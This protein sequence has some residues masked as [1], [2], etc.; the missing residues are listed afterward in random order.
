MDWPFLISGVIIIGITWLMIELLIK[1]L[2]LILEWA[3]YGPLWARI[4]LWPVKIILVGLMGWAVAT[5]TRDA[6]RWLNKPKD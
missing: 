4:I 6:Y 3:I 5:A 1:I 2:T